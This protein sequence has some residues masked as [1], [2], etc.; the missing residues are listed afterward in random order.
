MSKGN[1][2]N[3][4]FKQPSNKNRAETKKARGKG[5]LAMGE[6]S[7]AEWTRKHDPLYGIKGTERH[8]K[9]KELRH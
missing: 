9:I 6:M 3:T 5:R 8:Q 4:D 2:V 7:Q 1:R